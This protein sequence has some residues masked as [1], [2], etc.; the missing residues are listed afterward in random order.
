[1]KKMYSHT[2]DYQQMTYLLVKEKFPLFVFGFAMILIVALS[3]IRT[4]PFTHVRTQKSTVKKLPVA[5][6]KIYR[7]QEGD[8]LWSI[9]EKIYGSG[10]NAMDIATL[11]HLDEPYVLTKDQMLLLPS[12]APKAPTQGE[13]TSTA[14]QTQHVSEYVVQEGD[15]LWQ[16]AEKLYG[17]GNQMQKL[18]DANRIPYPYNVEAGQ[19]LQV[20]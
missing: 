4:I 16:I 12:V 8:D 5:P 3:A 14:A 2:V 19:T 18:I 10:F 7:V 13:I 20:P 11:N 9:A 6:F 17:D 1:M 15:Y